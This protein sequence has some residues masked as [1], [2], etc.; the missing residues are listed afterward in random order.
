MITQDSP[1]GGISSKAI[2]EIIEKV[3]LK[4]TIS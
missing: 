1:E 3:I 2:D 4:K